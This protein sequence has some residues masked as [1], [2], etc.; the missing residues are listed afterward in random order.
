M[1]VLNK[2]LKVHF[3]AWFLLMEHERA[4]TIHQPHSNGNNRLNI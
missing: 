3:I 4:D 2:S 1:S